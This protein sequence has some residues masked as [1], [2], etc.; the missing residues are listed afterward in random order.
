MILLLPYQDL[1]TRKIQLYENEAFSMYAFVY[2][3]C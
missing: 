1:V 3:V 2:F